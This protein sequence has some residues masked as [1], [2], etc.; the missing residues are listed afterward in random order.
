MASLR[1][2]FIVILFRGWRLI[3]GICC[4]LSK[5][6]IPELYSLLCIILNFQLYMAVGKLISKEIHLGVHV[7]NIQEKWNSTW[8]TK[9]E[10]YK[11][12]LLILAS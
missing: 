7:Q 10:I 12:L 3:L 6:F 4:L 8:M 2:N 5:Y 1:F 11:S 9:I